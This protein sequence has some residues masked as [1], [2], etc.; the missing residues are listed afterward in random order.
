MPG[1]VIRTLRDFLDRRLGD[2]VE[3]SSSDGLSVDSMA[4]KRAAYYIGT[5]YIS[6][7][8]SKCEFKV[9]RDGTSTRDD[10]MWYALNVRPNPNQNGSQFVSR[11]MQDYFYDG[12]A[13]VVQPLPSRGWL[14]VADSFGVEERPLSENLFTSVVVDNG[15]ALD[16]PVRAG[17]C[18]YFRLEDVEVRSIVSGM[19]RD[20]GELLAS[21][22]E[23]YMRGTGEKFVYHRRARPTGTR[24]DE[25]GSADEVNDALKAFL[26]GENGV[27]P[28]PVEHSLERIEPSARAATSTDVIALRK[29]VYETVASA[30][31]IPVSMMYGNM[32]NI[33]DIVN[34][35]VTFAVDP[36]AQMMSDEMTG[37]LFTQEEVMRG[38]KVV[39]DTSRV[40][41]LDMFQ[42]ADKAD[43][44]ISSGTAC[45]DEVREPLGMDTLNTEYS[46]AHWVTR[47]YSP[48]E[49]A[50]EMLEDDASGGGEK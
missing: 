43:K 15:F 8:I 1:K 7:A 19:Y 42:V 12:H 48:L 49:A 33:S 50:L 10:P 3:I 4:A 23:S 5:S 37:T 31:K 6:N 18:C 44:L 29:D 28:L 24:K 36:I 41:H 2:G 27:L 11:L 16:R 40:Q 35:F 46:R 39:V 38:C 34:Q 9:Y 14:Y 25:K 30:L 22:M 21:A 26:K 32:T 17:D 20:Y 13:L 47:N 45:I